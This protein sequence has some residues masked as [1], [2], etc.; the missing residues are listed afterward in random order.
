MLGVYITFVVA[1]LA[2]EIGGG[3]FVYV[4]KDTVFNG[5]E[6]MAVD[7]LHDKYT[8]SNKSATDTAWDTVMV[9]VSK[10]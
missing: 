3:V 2:A 4:K 6:K 9:Q 1:I 5:V 10:E 8:E 7:Y